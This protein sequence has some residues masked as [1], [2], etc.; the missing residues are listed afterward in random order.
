MQPTEQSSQQLFEET[1]PEP[2]DPA[3]PSTPPLPPPQPQRKQP[4]SSQR[5]LPRAPGKDSAKILRLPRLTPKERSRLFWALG[6]IIA[7]ALMGG[8]I[9][10]VTLAASS[11]NTSPTTASNQI[12]STTNAPTSAPTR[13]AAAH[14][15]VGDSITTAN[16]QVTIT[17][18]SAYEGNPNRFETPRAGDTF[19]VVQ[20][21]FK[22]L[23][24][25]SQPLSTL[26]FFTLQDTQGNTYLEAVLNSVNAP[27]SPV[28]ANRSTQ[29][30]WGYEVPASLHTFV[31]IF[32]DDPG[33]TTS[34][35]DITI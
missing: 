4:R 15:Q 6:G 32:S 14:H 24:N 33:Q 30:E 19:L 27:D 34:A 21:T 16:W 22:N 1:P 20:G 2:L 13:Q 17:S 23:T 35:W 26:L 8:I 9:G 18:A 12:A 25:Q 7:V 31:L 28:F 29:G 10:A 5:L 11:K 3:E